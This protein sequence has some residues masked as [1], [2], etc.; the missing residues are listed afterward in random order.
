[1][2][3]KESMTYIKP[4]EGVDCVAVV[5]LHISSLRLIKLLLLSPKPLPLQLQVVVKDCLAVAFTDGLSI[6]AGL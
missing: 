6:C 2:G 4:E 1:V 3:V 5:L